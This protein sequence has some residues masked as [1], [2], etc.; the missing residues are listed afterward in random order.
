MFRVL[1][2]FDTR[3]FVVSNFLCTLCSKSVCHLVTFSRLRLIE[4]S[5]FT[6]GSEVAGDPLCG[7]VSNVTAGLHNG[8]REAAVV[9]VWIVSVKFSGGGT[10]LV[11]PCCG[12]GGTFISA[13][14]AICQSHYIIPVFSHYSEVSEHSHRVNDNCQFLNSYVLIPWL[15]MIKISHKIDQRGLLIVVHQ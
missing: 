2:V 9:G 13:G 7:G 5:N 15:Q 1:S 10:T 3:L 14:D 8:L 12:S 11:N 6:V 4:L